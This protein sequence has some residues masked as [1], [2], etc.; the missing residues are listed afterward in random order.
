MELFYSIYVTFLEYFFQDSLSDI[1][2]HEI[3]NLKEEK[4]ISKS[5]ILVLEEIFP[6]FKYFLANKFNF[7][8]ICCCFRP[9]SNKYRQYFYQKPK[10]ILDFVLFIFLHYGSFF[11]KFKKVLYFFEIPR[12]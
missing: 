8:K 7:L 9:C 6:Y 3:R 1:Q 5:E 12:S 11:K 4:K 2:K 10:P